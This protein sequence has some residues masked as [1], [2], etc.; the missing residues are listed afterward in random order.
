[1]SFLKNP[2]EISCFRKMCYPLKINT[3]IIII[4]VIII[5]FII[6]IIEE[7]F[8]ALLMGIKF[9]AKFL[10]AFKVMIIHFKAY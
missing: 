2:W 6:I 7:L 5:I 4:I 10:P 9:M 1:M 8:N 3:I